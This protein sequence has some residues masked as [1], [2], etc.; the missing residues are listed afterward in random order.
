MRIT[1]NMV[2]SYIKATVIGDGNREVTGMMPPKFAKEGDVTFAVND[3]MFKLAAKSGAVCVLATEEKVRYP[4]TILKVDD[5]KKSMVMMYNAMLSMIP[6]KEGSIHPTA[7]VSDTAKLGKNVHLG[8]NAVIEDNVIIGKDSCIGAG[9]VICENAILG[10]KVTLKPNVTICS[11][12]VIASKV[13]IHSGT[14]IGADG[15]GYVPKDGKIYKVPQMGYVVIEEGVEIGANTCIDRGTFENTVIGAHTKIDNLVQ[16]SHNDKIGRQVLIAAQVGV[17]GSSSIGDGT[18]MGGQVGIA[19]H[20]DVGKNVKLGAKCGVAGKLGD[21]EVRL[22]YPALSVADTRK[23]DKI[24][25]MMMK[26]DK[27]FRKM[28]KDLPEE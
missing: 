13:T 7:V 21:D 16:I 5:M 26:N 17:A 27:K 1:V 22:R 9:C 11:E 25:M 4:K 23:W 8:A 18:M 2:A 6:P 10:D 24:F 20:A 14:V 28:I 15:F 19:D 12:T 3:E